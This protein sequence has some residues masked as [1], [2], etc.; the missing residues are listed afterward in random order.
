MTRLAYLRGDTIFD[1]IGAG[2][3]WSCVTP[4]SSTTCGVHKSVTGVSQECHK[5]VTRLV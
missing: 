2:A 5:S 4:G 1:T 3:V